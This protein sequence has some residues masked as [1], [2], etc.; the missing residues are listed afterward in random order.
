MMNK[1]CI[2]NIEPT[3]SEINGKSLNYVDLSV[4]NSTCT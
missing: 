4:I 1:I 2:K 3:N